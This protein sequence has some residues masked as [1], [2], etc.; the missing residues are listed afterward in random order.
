MMKACDG[1]TLSVTISGK[2]TSPLSNVTDWLSVNGLKCKFGIH[3]SYLAFYGKNLP[4]AVS[5]TPMNE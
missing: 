4:F 1:S 5:G 3:P 2:I